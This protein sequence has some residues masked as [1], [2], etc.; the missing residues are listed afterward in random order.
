[1]GV[2]KHRLRLDTILHEARASER[3]ANLDGAL[4]RY[5]EALALWRTGRFAVLLSDLHM[6]K[7]DGFELLRR[8]RLRSLPGLLIGPGTSF[9]LGIL[10]RPQAEALL[11]RGAGDE[12]M[13][14]VLTN[15]S[16]P[17]SA[18]Q[19]LEPDEDAPETS[20][21]Y[22]KRAIEG[23]ATAYVC[24]GPQCSPPVTKANE[25]LSMLQSLRLG[26]W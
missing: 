6:P 22:G 14:E 3:E 10:T 9:T 7:L 23:R 2:P 21:A 16:L 19:W 4:A 20:P 18:V 12:L 5:E 17:G 15:I 13:R 25:L 24:S 11:I 8:L 1:M 26:G